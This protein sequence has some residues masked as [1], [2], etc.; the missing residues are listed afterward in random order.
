[1][2]DPRVF[3]FRPHRAWWAQALVT[4]WR[5]AFEILCL[6]ALLS[7][8]H[9]L[10]ESFGITPTVFWLAIWVSVI[11][12]LIVPVTRDAVLGVFWV[13]VTRH[14]LRTF[15][16]E[17]RVFNR[18]GK[19]PWVLSARPT[20]VG[21]RCWVWLMP[22]LSIHDFENA[23]EQIATATWARTA[24]VER[25]VRNGSLIRVDVV[26]RD[27][28]TARGALASVLIPPASAE[29][30]RAADI[31]AYPGSDT[32][33]STAAAANSAG[34]AGS[35]GLLRLPRRVI[36][37]TTSTTPAATPQSPPASRRAPSRPSMPGPAP[38][39]GAQD[40]PRSRGAGGED[41]SD[42]L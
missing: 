6:I 17:A 31:T 4:V 10:D 19:L 22:G 15:F 3:G 39:S 29:E 24:R 21:E 37:L 23:A 13:F 32:P 38:A 40:S 8:M 2:G 11:V 20:A 30:K 1:M 34:S 33:A 35:A 25:H 7:V 18:S 36:D 41:V 42:Y 9:R 5:W 26:R 16:V 28:L 14:R 27:P 12:L